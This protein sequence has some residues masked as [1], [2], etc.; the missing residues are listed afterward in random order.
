MR[1]PLATLV[2]CALFFSLV[3]CQSD[4]PKTEPARATTSADKS[5]PQANP[6]AQQL[7]AEFRPFIQGVWV[8]QPYL[9]A[10]QRTRSAE[11]SESK[12]FNTT[13]AL[14]LDL[15]Q[16][17]HDSV[18]VY[19]VENNHEGDEFWL[20]LRRGTQPHSLQVRRGEY[21][22]EERQGNRWEI[23]YEVRNH[24]TTLAFR[25]LTPSS[26]VKDEIRYA[27]APRRPGNLLEQAPV[28]DAAR[29]ILFAG[30]YDILYPSGATSAVTFTADGTL[31]GLGTY[32]Y[33]EPQTDF[34]TSSGDYVWFMPTE[35]ERDTARIMT[36]T[37]RWRSDTLVL[38]RGILERDTTSG[39]DTL[40]RGPLQFRLLRR[41]SAH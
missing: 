25:C 28:T 18:K 39:T 30:Q 27:R 41:R 12:A 33:F 15:S 22:P 21:D 16:L 24:D 1:S 26:R 17:T 29:R 20:L 23:S 11:A 38:H 14:T 3:G 36:C 7:L 8:T 34:M 35:E 31:S 19:A 32:H 9:D 10:L 13:T 37:Y 6:A 4:P 40:M 5:S 2:V